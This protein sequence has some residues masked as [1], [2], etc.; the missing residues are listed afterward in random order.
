MP[1]KNQAIE[2]EKTAIE[3]Q[4]QAIDVAINKMD[5][6]KNTRNKAMALFKADPLEALAESFVASSQPLSGLPEFFWCKQAV[7]IL[8]C[9]ATIGNVLY[10][11]VAVYSSRLSSSIEYLFNNM[12]IEYLGG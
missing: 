3:S 10:F 2:A 9:I 1:R 12:R 4:N 6:N 8:N 7:N 5:A 11:I